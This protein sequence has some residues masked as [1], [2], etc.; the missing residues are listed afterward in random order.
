MIE[1]GIAVGLLA[2]FAGSALLGFAVKLWIPEA[3]RSKEVL[4]LIQLVMSLLVTF[5][6]LVL[7]LLTTSVKTSYDKAE[8]D[9]IVFAAEITQLDRCLRNYGSGGELPREKLRSYTAGVIAST[10]PD[11]PRPE[12]VDYPDPNRMARTGADAVLAEL[13]NRVGLD[14]RRLDPPDA[15]HRRLADACIDDYK[16]VAQA[17]L[18]VVDDVYSSM[19]VAFY[20]AVVFWL[21]VVFSGFGLS[22]PWNP[23]VGVVLL[24]GAVAVT[25]ALVLIVD[26]DLPYE[27]LF[28]IP[29]TAMRVALA[30]LSAS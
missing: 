23:T 18:G 15:I 17:R 21:S 22:A 10:W 30:H 25:I 20:C 1:L 8:H 6:A 13:M 11:E 16:L 27:G 24:L 5:T 4:Q 9:R 29:S 3:H 28:G 12:G 14:I 26:L 19:S 7:G 2:L